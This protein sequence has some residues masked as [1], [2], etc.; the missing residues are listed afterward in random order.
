MIDFQPRRADEAETSKKR[1]NEK[2]IEK[3]CLVPAPRIS[4]E[5]R[6]SFRN[7]QRVMHFHACNNNFVQAV[8]YKHL[9]STVNPNNIEERFLNPGCWRSRVHM[10][11]PS[12]HPA[13]Q[14]VRSRTICHFALTFI[15]MKKKHDTHWY[16]MIT[17]PFCIFWCQNQNT[18]N[19]MDNRGTRLGLDFP[20]LRV[21]R[22]K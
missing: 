14:P 22:G 17:R 2:S 10:P 13:T 11:K 12:S 18:W 6:G 21:F 5:V 1:K 16:S 4:T 19:H 15:L 20:N 3:H 9:M 8:E 7:K